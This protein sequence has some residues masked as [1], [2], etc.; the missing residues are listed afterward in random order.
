[1]KKQKIEVFQRTVRDLKELL[2]L[3]MEDI[4][5]GLLVCPCCGKPLKD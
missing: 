4:K 2:D 1:M 5:K 3:D